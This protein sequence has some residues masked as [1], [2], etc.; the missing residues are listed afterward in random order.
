MLGAPD[1]TDDYWLY[2]GSQEAIE[3]SIRN[4]RMGVMPAHK[5]LLS[6]ERIHVLAAYVYSLSHEQR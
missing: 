6:P 5:D 4:G 3:T 1:L 2:G